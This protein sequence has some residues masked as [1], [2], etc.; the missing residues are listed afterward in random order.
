MPFAI[1]SRDQFDV[2][3]PPSLLSE[4]Y[5]RD[6]NEVKAVGQ[7]TSPV[8]NE[9]QAHYAHFSFEA[10]NVAWSRIA[11]IY[12]WQN[13]TNLHDTARLF[14][15]LNMAMADGY[16]AG[17]A[18]EAAGENADSRVFIGYHFRF[19][20][21]AGMKL[22]RWIGTFAFRHNLGPRRLHEW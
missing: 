8:R 3:L 13:D 11:A 17:F 20:T 5:A 10:S 18:S 6:F 16:I 19:A 2:E 1:R 4:A 15:L 7:D 12:T 14:A 9:D 21:K 22:G